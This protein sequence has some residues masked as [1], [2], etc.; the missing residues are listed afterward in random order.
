M[1]VTR[2]NG[3]LSECRPHS[4]DDFDIVVLVQVSCCFS[5][6]APRDFLYHV[7]DIQRLGRTGTEINLLGVAG[8]DARAGVIV[9]MVGEH[10]A[11][12]VTVSDSQEFS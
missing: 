5:V 8:Q 3:T 12:G 1:T 4:A 6:L 10:A 2:P 7:E 11:K 9:L